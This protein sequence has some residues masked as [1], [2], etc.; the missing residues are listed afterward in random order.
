MI[1]KP[2]VL[3]CWIGNKDIESAEND[4]IGPILATL[5]DSEF[6]RCYLIYSYPE[7][8]VTPYL[9]WLRKQTNLPV[10]AHFEAL[11][12]PVHFG[13]IYEAA[14]KHLQHIVASGSE[15][16]VQLTPGTPAMQA[17]W[18]L[19]GKTRYSATFYQSSPEKGV[20][21]VDIPFEIAAEYIPAANTISDEKIVQLSAYGVAVNTAFDSIITQSKRMLRLKSQA[22]ILAT[23]HVPVLIY[24]ETG[25][26]KEMFA[27]AICNAS[28]RTSAPFIAINCGAIPPELVDSTLFGHCKGAFTG[29][30]SNSKGVFEQADGGTLF[31]DEFGELKPDVQVRLLR[32]LQE[33]VITPVGASEPVKVNVR[34][35]TATHSDL[36][37]EV[38]KGRFRADLVYRIAVGVLHLPPLREREG[39]ILLLAD[40][41]LQG[42]SEQ[43]QSLQNKQL[44]V[45]AKNFILR[46]PWRGNVRELHSTL[47]RAAIWSPDAVITADDI[48]E[49]LFMIPEEQQGT[50]LVDILEGID[51]QKV[52][53]KIAN[54]YLYRAL[55]VTGNN[56]THAA[57][58]LGLKSQQTFTN[59]LKKHQIE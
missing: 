39:D 35:I 59:W 7:R 25:T 40:T 30:V 46:C 28:P 37:Q 2:R 6:D 16:C 50:S 10:T 20:E 36:M 33:G 23:K 42:I 15:L 56:K 1:E 4:E 11:S 26:G 21:K 34:L 48:K 49:A 38:G 3:I 41:L 13:E 19:L 22:Q 5:Q 8:R 51:L 32:V 29:A 58:L 57:Q 55:E 45:E 9:A 47:L 17:V 18:V 53:S 27:R 44:S 24:G 31:L 54:D 12:S 43:D 52:I 14:N